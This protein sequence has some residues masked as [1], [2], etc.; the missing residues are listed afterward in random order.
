MHVMHSMHHMKSMLPPGPNTVHE[1]SAAHGLNAS[2]ES[3]D[4]MNLCL[5]VLALQGFYALHAHSSL[6]TSWLFMQ[7]AQSLH[8]LDLCS[9]GEYAGSIPTLLTF[10]HVCSWCTTHCTLPTL[11]TCWMVVQV[12]TLEVGPHTMSAF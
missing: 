5:A 6:Q 8:L 9:G 2:H 12:I 7:L 4:A 1:F 10:L 11:C 3:N